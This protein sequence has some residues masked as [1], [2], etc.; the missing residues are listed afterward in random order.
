LLPWPVNGD[1]IEKRG[2]Q[3]ICIIWRKACPQEQMPP[4]FRNGDAL[5]HAPV[6]GTVVFPKSGDCVVEGGSLSNLSSLRA[7][8]AASFK[9][10][11]LSV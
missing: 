8:R 5:T 3:K 2:A 6:R 1:L 4:A 11:P 10:I 7:K 9:V